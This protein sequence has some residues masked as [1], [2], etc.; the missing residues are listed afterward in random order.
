MKNTIV[1]GTF[2]LLISSSAI[3]VQAAEI[4]WDRDKQP[5]ITITDKDF[6]VDYR[7]GTSEGSMLRKRGIYDT[8]EEDSASLS[9]DQERDRRAAAPRRPYRPPAPVTRP[10]PATP[11]TTPKPVV[12]PGPVKPRDKAP[13]SVP[14]APKDKPEPNKM[15]WGEKKADKTKFKWGT[16]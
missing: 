10:R 5:D 8:R 12:T 9:D 11:V 13:V 15:K 14:V 1:V 2:I 3:A 16:N 6:K 4:Y 7:K